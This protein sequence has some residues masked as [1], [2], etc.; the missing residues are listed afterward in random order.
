MKVSA[1]PVAPHLAAEIEALP[2]AIDRPFRQEARRSRRRLAVVVRSAQ[3][4]VVDWRRSPG[5]IGGLGACCGHKCPC[6][7]KDNGL[8]PE[9]AA[10]SVLTAPHQRGRG[11]RR[12]EQPADTKL[13][14]MR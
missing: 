12:L 2:S 13:Q 1:D 9:H 8:V 3:D 10:I 11:N 4:R 7:A 14:V 6:E 5:L